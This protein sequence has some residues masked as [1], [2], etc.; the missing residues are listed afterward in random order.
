MNVLNGGWVI[1]L[2]SR[3]RVVCGDIFPVGIA[4]ESAHNLPMFRVGRI[5]VQRST[6]A[7][8]LKSQ[9]AGQRRGQGDDRFIGLHKGLAVLSGRE[10]FGGSDNAGCF[11]KRI[12]KFFRPSKLKPNPFARMGKVF[13]IYHSL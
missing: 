10:R 4:G 7:T 9:P 13:V 12:Y 6:A 5:E 2:R 3:L 11:Q 8:M 1:I